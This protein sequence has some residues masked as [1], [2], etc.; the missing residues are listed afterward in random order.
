MNLLHLEK[1]GLRGL[2]ISESFKQGDAKSKL[3]GVVM[4]RDF[5]IDGFVF[6]TCTVEGDDATKSILEMYEKLERSDINFILISG[7]IIAMY[8]VVDIS[9]I[10]KK[11]GLPVIGVTYEESSGIQDAIRHHF[12]NSSQSKIAQYEKLGQRHTITLHSGYDLHIRTEGCTVKDAKTILD[13]FTLQGS[14]PEPL[15]VAHLLAKSV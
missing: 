10:Y 15:R 5:V 14:I 2:S 6:G 3:A 9:Q 4:R 13:N 7:L 8:N 1:K 12:P 11:T